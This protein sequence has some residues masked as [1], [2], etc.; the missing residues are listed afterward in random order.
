MQ[1]RATARL[2]ELPRGK[3]FLRMPEGNAP[4]KER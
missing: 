1:K 2:R 4:L 3:T